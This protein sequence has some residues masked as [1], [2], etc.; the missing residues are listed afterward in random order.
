MNSNE[1]LEEQAAL[2]ALGLLDDDTRLKLMEDADRDPAAARAVADYA[3]AA[4]LLALEIPPVAPVPELRERIMDQLPPAHDFRK[5]ILSPWVPYA[6]AA[7]L[8]LGIII[9]AFSLHS[10][11]TR[12]VAEDAELERLYQSDALVGLRL[13]QLEIRDASYQTSKIVIAWDPFRHRGVISMVNLPAPAPGRSYQLWVL[14]PGA[15]APVS[16]GLLHPEAGSGTFEVPAVT[17]GSPGFAVTLEP[18]QGSPEPTSAIL[19]AVAPGQ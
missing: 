8:M 18:A 4:A 2:Q 5:V 16:A 11:K 13:A 3:E 12:I 15:Q 10:L 19:F 7:C 6:M 17:T 1:H 14:D 9:L